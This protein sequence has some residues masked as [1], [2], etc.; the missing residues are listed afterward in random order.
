MNA[1]ARINGLL[2]SLHISIPIL[3]D[4]AYHEGYLVPS[5]IPN[6]YTRDRLKELSRPKL[7]PFSRPPSLSFVGYRTENPW[8]ARYIHA[9]KSFWRYNVMWLPLGV[10]AGILQL[11]YLINSLRVRW[12][13]GAIASASFLAITCTSIVLEGNARKMY[14]KEVQKKVLK[15]EEDFTG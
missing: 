1:P 2:F 5:T 14:L 15:E 9:K 3:C 13:A 6:F 4:L 12:A 11:T 10:T 8:H 7:I